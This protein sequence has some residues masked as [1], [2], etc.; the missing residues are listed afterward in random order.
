MLK[1]LF[2]LAA[3]LFLTPLKVHAALELSE[4]YANPVGD[5]TVGEWIELY[6]PENASASSAGYVLSD[7][8]G[9][10]KSFSLP[11][12]TVSAKGFLIVWR[13]TS[14]ISLN[15]DGEEVLLKKP[16][17]TTETSG[18]FASTE[19]KSWTKNGTLWQ[20]ADPT[21]GYKLSAATTST[22]QSA[23]SSAVALNASVSAQQTAS[24]SAIAQT[25]SSSSSALDVFLATANNG[26]SEGAA[27]LELR[28]S[29]VAACATPSEWAEVELLGAQSASL[30]GW[31]FQ[32]G[33]G[34]IHDL[35]DI[36]LPGPGLYVLQW[37]SGWLTNSGERLALVWN[38]HVLEELLL[39]PCSVGQ[40][41]VR[42]GDEW[43]LTN[44]PSPGS[45]NTLPAETPSP[46][47]LS[48]SKTQS[49]PPKS[50]F[51]LPTLH[52][53]DTASF[54]SKPNIIPR[55][56]DISPYAENWR[57]PQSFLALSASA[58]HAASISSLR[59]RVLLPARRNFPI[60]TV[61]MGSAFIVLG[62]ALVIFSHR[63]LLW[64]MLRSKLSLAIF[65]STSYS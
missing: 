5:E 26:Q 42:I 4:I 35:S 27:P 57:L 63:T 49:S 32:D 15:N 7:A 34:N 1:S 55:V 11:A 23:T 17:G 21:M 6:N 45:P 3:L 50:T 31:S 52:T 20:E 38:N 51:G 59:H 64:R 9:V 56:Q 16:D 13:T 62:Q 37:K 29:E 24:N 41:F 43:Q 10:V 65:P 28:L 47:V 61:F 36:V 54:V 8:I 33:S 18:W 25:T 22:V 12:A 30:N 44:T 46:V 53:S 40:S 58:T 48:A 2:F 14:G 60:P 39:P 19:G